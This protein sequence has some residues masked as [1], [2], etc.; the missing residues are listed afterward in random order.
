MPICCK[1]LKQCL[2][3]RFFDKFLPLNAFAINFRIEGSI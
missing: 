3:G 1:R 2:Q